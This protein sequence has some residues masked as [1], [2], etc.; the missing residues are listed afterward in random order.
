MTSVAPLPLRLF[1]TSGFV[2]LGPSE[3]IEEEELPGYV[4]ENYY[5]VCIGDV[6]ASRYQVIANSDMAYLRLHG[7]AAIFSGCSFSFAAF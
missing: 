7:F 4:A 3:K 5:P 6:F 1:L 2:E